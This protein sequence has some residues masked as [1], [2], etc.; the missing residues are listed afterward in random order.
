VQRDV[1][2]HRLRLALNP[3]EPLW[4]RLIELFVL[5]PRVHRVWCDHTVF[6]SPAFPWSGWSFLSSWSCGFLLVGRVS[7]VRSGCGWVASI[8]WPVPVELLA[9][10]GSSSMG[11]G[12]GFWDGV[13]PVGVGGWLLVPWD[14]WMIGLGLLWS[15]LCGS[16]CFCFLV[17]WRLLSGFLGT[18]GLSC[19]GTT[20]A[21]RF[22]LNGPEALSAS[23]LDG[24]FSVFSCCLRLSLCC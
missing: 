10:L 11:I 13:V 17:G 1:A 18:M 21:G 9:T 23:V 12:S 2:V 19:F 20:G 22:R 4:S 7:V 6:S 3:V 24:V 5:S 14:S 16:R 8:C 15:V